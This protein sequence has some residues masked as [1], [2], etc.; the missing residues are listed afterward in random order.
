[1]PPSGVESVAWQVSG[2]AGVSEA[3]MG[4]RKVGVL[5]VLL[6][7][8]LLPGMTGCASQTLIES[9]P[10]GATVIVDG[11][12]FVGETPVRVQDFPRVGERR[13][14]LVSKEGYYPRVTQLQSRIH[15]RHLIACVCSLGL[16]WPMVIFGQYPTSAVVTL[17]RQSP[18]PVAHFEERPRVD[19]GQ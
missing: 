17:E 13:E 10:A 11:D 2:V 4:V 16:A 15:Q 18:P 6:T 8:L 7:G 1:V 14:Y 9:R 5:T 3:V 19:F 12:R